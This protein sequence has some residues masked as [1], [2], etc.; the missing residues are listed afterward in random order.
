MLDDTSQQE[1]GVVEAGGVGVLLKRRESIVEPGK[2][3][4]GEKNTKRGL[5]R[6]EGV[7]GG[8]LGRVPEGNLEEAS[9]EV[10]GAVPGGESGTVEVGRLRL[11]PRVPLERRQLLVRRAH[12]PWSPPE[13]SNK[14]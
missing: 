1:A 2:G 11:Q 6:R 14:W 12:L 4:V 13:V 10:H 7:R 5:L 3:E 9:G 8:A